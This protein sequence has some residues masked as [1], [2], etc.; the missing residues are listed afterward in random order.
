MELKE[1]VLSSC[2]E[3]LE[4]LEP[5]AEVILGFFCAG[6]VVNLGEVGG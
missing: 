6:L 5:E 4:K 3:S 2:Q 1:E